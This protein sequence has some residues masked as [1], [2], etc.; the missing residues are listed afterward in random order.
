MVLPTKSTKKAP[1]DAFLEFL[2]RGMS[3]PRL[4]FRLPMRTVRR[5][6]LRFLLL[7]PGTPNPDGFHIAELST[8]L[9]FAL[10]KLCRPINKV[11]HKQHTKLQAP[12]YKQCML[13]VGNLLIL[14]F[15]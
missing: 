9:L 15:V 5:L 11:V 6:R 1:K 7:R 4:R 3:Y 12:T 14:M 8:L 10:S 2:L 13:L